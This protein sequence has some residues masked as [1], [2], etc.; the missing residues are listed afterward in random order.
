MVV[1]HFFEEIYS[2]NEVVFQSEFTLSTIRVFLHQNV[3]I[4]D[5]LDNSLGIL[6]D[7]LFIFE[8]FFNERCPGLSDA[9]HHVQIIGK[10]AI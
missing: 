3:K 1:Y 9:C 8:V 4:F 6:V 2:L 7:E 5:C 10:F